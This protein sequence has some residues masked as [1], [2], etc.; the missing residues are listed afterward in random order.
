MADFQKTLAVLR[1]GVAV[2]AIAFLASGAMAENENVLVFPGTP[3][4]NQLTVHQ[5]QSGG[6]R[7]SLHVAEENSLLVGDRWM[8]P[9]ASLLDPGTITQTGGNNILMASVN[10]RGNQL[11]VLQAGTRHTVTI[12][13]TGQ[14]NLVSVLQAGSGSH[15]A[16]TQ[17]GMRNSVAI[18]QRQW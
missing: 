14:S 4:K 10:G 1:S 11:A 16:V 2:L 7:A 3:I 9:L 18:S 6:H 5:S 13:S 8:R 12:W 17:A 15:A